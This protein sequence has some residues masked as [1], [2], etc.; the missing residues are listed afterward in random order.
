MLYNVIHTVDGPAK[1]ESPVDRWQVYPMKFVAFQPSVWWC[2]AHA[3]KGRRLASLIACSSALSGVTFIH[4]TVILGKI[5][6]R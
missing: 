1:S 6:G 4:E 2:P 5:V 3:Q